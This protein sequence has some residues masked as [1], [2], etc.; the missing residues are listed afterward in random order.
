MRSALATVPAAERPTQL[1]L[2]FQATLNSLNEK[3]GRMIAGLRRFT[4]RQRELARRIT[5]ETRQAT[6]LEQDQQAASQVADLRD[7]QAWDRRIYEERQKTTR[8]LCDQPG[9]LERRAYAVAQSL[10]GLLP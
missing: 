10:T 8:A 9:V 7:A 3:R 2:L 5:A 4:R 6:A 1:T